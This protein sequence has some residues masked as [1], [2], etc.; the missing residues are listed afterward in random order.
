MSTQASIIWMYLS[1]PEKLIW[2]TSFVLNNSS[3]VEEVRRQADA[4]VLLFRSLPIEDHTEVPAP[5]SQAAYTN[6][7]IKRSEFNVW[8]RIQMQILFGNRPRFHV[9]SD[10]E[11][12]EA[13][14]RYEV[15]RDSYF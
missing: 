10:E 14:K 4:A 2:A 3:D 12:E 9:P 13:F 5:E 6:T 1:E 15:G 8:Y 7:P 11:C